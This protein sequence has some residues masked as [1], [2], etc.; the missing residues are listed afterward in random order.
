VKLI[1]KTTNKT[2]PS[3]RSEY[4]I[5]HYNHK[6]YQSFPYNKRRADFSSKNCS[7]AT[8]SLRIETKS[9]SCLIANEE[10]QTTPTQKNTTKR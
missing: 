8:F 6:S 2:K 4:N 1:T 5:N 10:E 7:I 9:H 3:N